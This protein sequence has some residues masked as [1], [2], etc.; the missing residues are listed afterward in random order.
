MQGWVRLYRKIQE[1]DTF[2]RLT[3]IQQLIAIYI[4]LNANHTDGVWYDRYKGIEVSLK[5]G[6]LITS[7]R[8]M[9]EEWFNKDKDV[10]EMKIRTT[11]TKLERLG[12]ITIE[13]TKQ[14]TL[15][16]VCNYSLYQDVETA[17][18]PPNNQELT[19]KQPS[20]NQAIT[21][22]KN[23]NNISSS[24]TSLKENNI[25]SVNAFEFYEQ[26]IHHTLSPFERD[27][28]SELIGESN[29]DLVVEAMKVAVKINKRRL[30][31]VETVLRDW[32]D[33]DITTAEQAINYEQQG[34]K[35]EAQGYS[36]NLGV[37]AE[38]K[39][40]KTSGAVPLFNWLDKDVG[41]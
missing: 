11:L 18:N 14:Y 6:Q 25:A 26:N 20:D 10:S 1:S 39:V 13:A 19:Q 34:K 8:K 2:Q 30:R 23:V 32:R 37:P 40:E 21:T 29:T 27:L 41:K 17:I 12:F 4:I 5:R 38:K 9:Y 3:A 36:S 22:N 24:S 33:K 31:T 16:T 7:R 28:L 15:I 35:A